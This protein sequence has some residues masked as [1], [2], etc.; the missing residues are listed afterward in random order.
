MALY[1]VFVALLPEDTLRN[2]KVPNSCQTCHKHKKEDLDELNKRWKA[3][4]KIPTPLGQPI[5]PIE[6]EYTK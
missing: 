1:H 3:L 4:A 2:P 5:E 6:Y